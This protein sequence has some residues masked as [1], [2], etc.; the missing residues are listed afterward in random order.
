MQKQVYKKR[1]GLFDD[2][3]NIDQGLNR[4]FKEKWTDVNRPGQPCGRAK[5]SVSCVD[6]RSKYR[7]K[8]L[9]YCRMYQ[10][11]ILPWQ[12]KRSKR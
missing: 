10:K 11:K 8:L 7:N 9:N 1:G 12:I 5:A 3:K 6:Q 2:P 4:W